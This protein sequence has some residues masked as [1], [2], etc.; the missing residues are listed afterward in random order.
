[1]KKRRRERKAR[2]IIR[3]HE[4]DINLNDVY[5]NYDVV[6]SDAWKWKFTIWYYG[7]VN[8]CS[9]GKCDLDKEMEMGFRK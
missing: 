3:P 2:V 9:F 7:N 6:S 8:I 4:I 5:L 1:M